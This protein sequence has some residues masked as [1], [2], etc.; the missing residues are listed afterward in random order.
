MD[1][2]NYNNNYFRPM[3][4]METQYGIRSMEV[5]IFIKDNYLY[6]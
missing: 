6:Y 2:Y 3:L 4:M 5:Q 1:S